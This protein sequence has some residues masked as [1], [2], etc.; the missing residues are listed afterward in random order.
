[1]KKTMSICLFTVILV[2]CFIGGIFLWRNTLGN[3]LR[4]NEL[5]DNT[6]QMAEVQEPELA[7]SMQIQEAYRYFLIEENGMLVVYEQDR[8][9]VMLETNI[10]LHGVDEATQRQLQEGIWITDEKE[11][12]D[13]LES[14]S[15]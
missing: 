11:L 4:N 1:M 2:V 6:E 14:Y 8:E 3:S 5:A 10:S 15:S 9:T 12:Y 7:E 13:F